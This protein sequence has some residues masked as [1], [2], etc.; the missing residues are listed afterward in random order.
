VG[1]AVRTLRS[2]EKLQVDRLEPSEPRWSGALAEDDDERAR[3]IVRAVSVLTQR[4]GSGRMLED[5]DR[6]RE[7]L[8]M[9]EGE[10]GSAQQVPRLRWDTAA[11]ARPR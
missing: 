10:V 11:V 7:L 1:A 4:P 5:A 8:E 6:V 9:D 3:D 2:G